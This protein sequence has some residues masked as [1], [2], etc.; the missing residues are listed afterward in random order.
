M[1]FENVKS[2]VDKGSRKGAGKGGSMGSLLLI[3][4]FDVVY[5]GKEYPVLMVR[6]DSSGNRH[7]AVPNDDESAQG[8][9]LRWIAERWIE[10]M[11]PKECQ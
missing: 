8:E 1:L 6:V 10:K 5:K 9:P 11:I 2:S 7:Y 4:P 3:R